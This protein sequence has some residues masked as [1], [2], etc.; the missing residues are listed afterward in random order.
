MARTIEAVYENGVFKPLESVQLEEG[1]RVQVYLP[2][3]PGS[4]PT[5]PEEVADMIRL[6]HSVFEGLSDQDIAEIESSWKR[7]K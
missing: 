3:E 6:A 4:G 5:T 7:D 2:Y 1:Q